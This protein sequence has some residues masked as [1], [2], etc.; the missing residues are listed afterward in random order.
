[1]KNNKVIFLLG[2][3]LVF[4]FSSRALVSNDIANYYKKLMNF[5]DSKHKEGIIKLFR[6]GKEA[7]PFLIKGIS[8]CDIV[9]NSLVNPTG[10][11][12][13]DNHLRICSGA[14]AAYVIEMILAID[15]IDEKKYFMEKDF[16]FSEIEHYLYFNGFIVNAKNDCVSQNKKEMTTIAGFYK[17]WW[18]KNSQKTLEELKKDWKDGIRPLSGSGFRWY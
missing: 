14:Y 17:E 18:E 1:V 10:S 4:L 7:I 16:L 9:T 15:H 3:I 13:T 5:S 12:L 6:S 2:W 11:L 8:C